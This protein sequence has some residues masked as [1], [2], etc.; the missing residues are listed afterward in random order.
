[1]L[2][3]IYFRLKALMEKAYGFVESNSMSKIVE[4]YTVRIAPPLCTAHSQVISL[5]HAL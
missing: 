3:G 1:M 2:N 4:A 5:T